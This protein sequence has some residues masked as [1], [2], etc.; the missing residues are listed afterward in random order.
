M[1]RSETLGTRRRIALPQGEIQYFESGTGRPVV[2]VHGLLTNAELWRAVVPGVAAAGNRCIAPD[3][4]LGGHS[5]PMRA[6]ADLTPSGQ[7]DV[8]A[9]FLEA[10]DLR[11]VVLV[12]ND[13]GGAIIQLLLARYP[14]RV[15]RVVLTPS[16]CFENFFPPMFAPLTALARVPGS[17]WPLAALTRIKALHRLPIMFGLVAKRPIPEEVAEA[18]LSPFQRS[19]GVRRDLRKFLR[20]VDR[21]LTIAAA[22]KLRDFHRPV[23]LVWAS[24]DKLFPMKFGRR[25]AD[26]LP[27]AR[28]VEVSD[29]YTFIPEDQP[30]VLTRHIVEFASAMAS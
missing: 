13:T 14:E 22:E 30:E 2:F 19:G 5:S 10:L 25:L 6:D 3:W 17:M 7:A 12:A 23:L 28:L 29:S 26:L 24:E 8:I 16:D 11:G 4:P 21:N 20:A 15:E 27:E 1:T 18:Y 9:S